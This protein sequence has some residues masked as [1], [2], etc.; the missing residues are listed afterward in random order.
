[1]TFPLIKKWL[2]LDIKVYHTQQGFS[3]IVL[4]DQLERRLAEGFELIQCDYC[5]DNEWTTHKEILGGKNGRENIATHKCLAI[6]K[7]PIKDTSSDSFKAGWDAC[8]KEYEKENAE[9]KRKLEIAKKALSKLNI[10]DEAIWD[11]WVSEYHLRDIAKEALK[12]LESA[13]E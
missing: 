4:A 3:S 6:G 10:T 12:E 7:Q 5:S 11:K 1:M 8:A 2:N 13:G 9:L